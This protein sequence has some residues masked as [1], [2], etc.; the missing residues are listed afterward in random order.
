M[1][2]DSPFHLKF[3]SDLSYGLSVSFYRRSRFCD[4]L[5]ILL[6]ASRSGIALKAFR[7]ELCRRYTHPGEPRPGIGSLPEKNRPAIQACRGRERVN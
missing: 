6:G 1:N 7:S 5:H 4:A 2:C 3:V